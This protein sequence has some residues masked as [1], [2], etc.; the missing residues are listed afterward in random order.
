M[1]VSCQN[2]LTLF[3]GADSDEEREEIKADLWRLLEIME[4]GP[5]LEASV[6]SFEQLRVACGGLGE[7]DE[8]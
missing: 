4:E 3:Q 7:G 5:A 1:T 6:E 2:L 8:F